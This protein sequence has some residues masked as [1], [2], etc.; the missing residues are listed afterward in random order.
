MDFT[1][2][3]CVSCGQV[4]TE[5]DDI[6]VCPECG[7]PHHRI[8][9]MKENKCANSLLHAEGVK[10]ESDKQKTSPGHDE[11]ALVI[12]PVCHFPN[13]NAD[14]KC[15]R[16]GADLDSDNT[17]QISPEDLEVR[18]EPDTYDEDDDSEFGTAR[19]YLGFDP[20]EDMG[21]A[22]LREL[23]QFIGTNTIYYIPIFK[24]MKDVGSKISFNLSCLIFPSFYFANRRMW[25]WALITTFVS[26]ALN[27][28]SVVIYM[29][30]DGFLTKHIADMVYNNMNYIETLAEVCGTFDW[31]CHIILCLFGNWLYFRHSLRSVRKIKAS[32]HDGVFDPELA[33][34]M[35]GVRPF[36]IILITIITC[37]IAMG[38]LYGIVLLLNAI[39]LMS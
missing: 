39:M 10:W 12:C 17:I 1:G 16:C 38:S 37:T 3:K 29:A 14:D 7:S 6:V 11:N 18:P 36:N 8:C 32:S 35:G 27:I 22:T 19:R 4:F 26:I 15:T 33:F 28:P 9:Y 34:S 20:N 13:R 23:S 5:D 24:R 21:G 2:E 25:L 31:I 30:D